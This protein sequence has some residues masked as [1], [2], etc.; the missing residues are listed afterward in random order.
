MVDWLLWRDGAEGAEGA[1]GAALIS[2]WGYGE[3]HWHLATGMSIA[4]SL[5]TTRLM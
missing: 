5:Y 3:W 2:L 1:E 4:P